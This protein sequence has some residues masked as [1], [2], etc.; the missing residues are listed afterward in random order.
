MDAIDRDEVIARSGE[1]PAFP[2]VIS[3][4]L[5]TLDDPESSLQ[6][7]TRHIQHDPVIT[8]RVLAMANRASVHSRHQSG[9]KDVFTAISLIGMARVREVAL[10]GAVGSF[11]ADVAPGGRAAGFWSHSVSVGSTASEIS[12]SI[13]TPMSVNHALIAGL[14]H[15]IGQLWLYRFDAEA[16]RAAWDAAL[17]HDIGIEQ[18]EA[19]RFGANHSQIGAW[20]ATHWMMPA[21]IVDSIAAHHRPDDEN[22]DPLVAVVHVAEVLSNALDLNGR[23]ENRV[24]G[25]SATACRRLGLTIDDGI[26]PLFGRIEARARY[27]TAYFT[28]V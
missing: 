1:L 24:T 10:Y 13:N 8:A 25:L 18:A 20:L 9:V 12:T 14:L 26:R 3:Q 16:Y 5:E 27:A 2:L 17:A 19:E 6:L 11:V 7:L 22:A 23:K 4:I 15:D 21:S 28:A